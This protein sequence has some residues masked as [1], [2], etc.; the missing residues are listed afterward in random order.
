MKLP[1]V[2][3]ILLLL[4]TLQVRSQ[5]FQ[6]LDS[7]KSG[8]DFKNV[9]KETP[10]ENIITYEYFYNGGGV[11]AGDLNNDGLTD[12][13]FTSN[14]DQSRIY[15]N[16]GNLKFE[17]I[18]SQSGI[19][20]Q[21]GWKTGIALA[22]VNNDGWLDIYISHSGN[23]SKNDRR[24]KLYINQHDLT[25]KEEARKYGVD[26][27]GYTSQSV[28]FDY[29]KDGDLD[30]FV[31]NHN[32]KLFRNFDAA[33]AKT[34]MDEDAGDR[35]YENTGKKFIDV[36]IR[37]GIISNPIGYG[38]GVVVTDTN[39]DGWPDFYVSNDYVEE[40]YLYINNKDGTF[41]NKLKDQMTC[42]SNFSMGVDAGDINN[43]GFLDLI[44][45]DMLPEDNKRQKL[46][47]APDNF[48]LYNNMVENGFHHQSMRNMLQLNN[49]NGTFSDI[50]QLSGISNTDWSWSPLLADFNNDGLVDLYVTNGYG[51][52]MISRDVMK[53][54]IDE[55]VKYIEG[56]SDQKM[57]EALQGIQST[58]LQNYFYL[59]KGNL[60]FENMTQDAGFQGVDFS[61]GAIYSDLDNDG[62]LEIIVNCMNAPA[63]VFKNLTRENSNSSNYITVKLTQKNKNIFAVG[64]KITVFTDSGEKLVRELNPTHGFQSSV[65]EPL[66]FG[67]GT[68]TADSIKIQWNDLSVQTIKERLPL[69]QYVEIKK[70][71]ISSSK[72]IKEK[73]L[74]SVRYD[75]INQPHNE[76]LVNDFKVQP[77]L[78]YMISYHGPKIKKVDFNKDGLDDLFFTSPE[79]QAPALLIQN[80]DGTFV[81]SN[82]PTLETSYFYEDT[83]ATFFDADGD[84]DLDLYV[85][86]GGFGAP[87][88]GIALE[89]RLY[90]NTDGEYTL[91]KTL[92]KD[93]QVGSVAVPWDFDQ[94]GDMDLFVGT[95]V[96]QSEFPKGAPSLILSNDGQGNF[97][98]IKLP[99]FDR[100]TDALVADF[101]GDQV[102]EL[103]VIGDWTYPK[104]FAFRNRSF[105]DLT[106]S[107]FS[108][109]LSGWWT[110]VKSDDLDGDGDLDLVMGN[111]GTN[112]QF[113]PS[114]E[115][116][117]ELY[118]DD[119]DNNGYI[120]PIWC[121]YV[122]GVSY[123]AVLR[124][125]LTDQIVSLRKKFVTYESYSEK[126]LEDIFSE[127]QL[128]NSP[129]CITD[130]IETTWFENKNGK[131]IS[132]KLPEEVNISSVQ[133]ISIH[134]FDQDGKKDLFLAG[135]VPFNRV[136]IGRKET[137]FGVY[138]KGDGKGNF[139]YLPN[140]K[141][142][143]AVQGSVRA[144]EIIQSKEK[145]KLV[146][147]INNSE[148]LIITVKNE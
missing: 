99:Y 80:Q 25:F 109:N 73:S 115:Y 60:K 37:A 131:F 68:Q 22:D 38:L 5:K 42:I 117:M 63:K 52:D 4:F 129:K 104:I 35:L 11:A 58:P 130:Y 1:K 101:D 103:L 66:H 91:S 21:N 3:F 146:V 69:N 92:P 44:T 27:F 19:E 141:T 18:T 26:D 6:L 137:S 46:L 126:T 56:D 82:Q 9:L 100:V 88:A 79:G 83:N 30:L 85:V 59:N 136:R 43:D 112:N 28:F 110:T 53:F 32:T 118:Y 96:K 97:K 23:Y 122:N 8:V 75:T 70:E 148:P 142:G 106:T 120:D 102:E 40:D 86:S 76:L 147:G 41:S 15:L 135:N 105:V 116:P 89:D 57:F 47:F 107:F 143:L 24:N 77:L 39:N 111:W 87:D 33:Y 10:N 125:E 114:K 64:S 98:Q 78:P 124:D 50:G 16:K 48:E 67:L 119:F 36:T 132:R 128:K 134:D 127:T 74:F 55:R 123:P 144:L 14:Q 31:L 54:Y 7:R 108:E 51:R 34:Q 84:G 121:Y 17:D 81:K 45:L 20:N 94:D 133:A 90:I 2:L 138:L 13:I 93:N 72:T 61:H 29:D 12:L 140:W 49:G 113:K 139:N 65:L 95:R 145:Q 62:D 71:S